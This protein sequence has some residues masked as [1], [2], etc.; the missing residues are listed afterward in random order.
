[1]KIQAVLISSAIA[2][3]MASPAAAALSL[4]P[5]TTVSAPGQNVT[6]WET[7][8]SRD[9]SRAVAL[10]RRFDGS[11]ERI[12][13]RNLEAGTWGPTAILSPSTGDGGS[14]QV[15]MSASGTTA[16]AVWKL[17]MGATSIL[18]TR[19]FNNGSWG[20]LQQIGSD[21]AAADPE[22]DITD[23]G[24]TALVV[25]RNGT[26][27]DRVI[28]AA[29]GHDGA[30]DAPNSL[31]S[32]GTDSVTPDV[33]LSGDGSRAVAIWRRYAGGVYSVEATEWAG[34]TWSPPQWLSASAQTSSAEVGVT[35]TGAVAAWIEVRGGTYRVLSSRRSA[36]NWSQESVLSPAGSNAYTPML[37]TRGSA[38]SLVWSREVGGIRIVEASADSGS[39][40][41]AVQVLS[42]PG[43][44]S[45]DP[46]VSVS[47]DTASAMAVWT[48]ATGLDRKVTGSRYANGVWEAPGD[49]SAVSQLAGNP[50]IHVDSAATSGVGFWRGRDGNV[51]LLRTTRVTD[52]AD[53]GTGPVT[54][55]KRPAAV[56]RLRTHIT[57]SHVRVTWR[58]A[59]DATSYR[60]VLKKR[61]KD[62]S[63]VRV[64]RT[65][66]TKFA[67]TSGRF[68]VT[69]TGLGSG[70][71][72]PAVSKSFRVP[73]R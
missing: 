45:Y 39:G 67:V 19:W 29:W 55:P 56:S 7:A 1:M 30:W 36:G 41:S 66:S 37:V 21:V 44:S 24:H 11:H 35:D 50:V 8:A 47:S 23:D 3:G 32:A 49:I 63:R 2:L 20:P 5:E 51:A 38:A 40:W 26:G 12:Q 42:R 62:G 53:G 59:A 68:R 58:S 71:R 52:Q 6:S 34:S 72:G 13:A 14:P 60:V 9:T 27:A 25:W 31:T 73:R 46:H 61:G 10:W 54:G 22:V 18:Q 17:E 48:V 64:V 70:G 28:R 15:A 16:V 69:V 33:D 65:L 43:E 4:D 57:K